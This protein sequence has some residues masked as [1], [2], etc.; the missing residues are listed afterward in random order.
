MFTIINDKN[1]STISTDVLFN[2]Y[3]S[4][5]AVQ[6]GVGDYYQA[7]DDDRENIKNGTITPGMSKKAVLMAYGYPPTH[8]TPLLTSDIWY[9]WY[10]RPSKVIVYFKDD[11]VF[12][13][14]RIDPKLFP[15]F[16]KSIVESEGGTK[17]R[18]KTKE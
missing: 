6:V 4:I 10:S 18:N 16:T 12:Q 14:E 3:F 15:I 8:K 5:E 17:S 1:T 9:Y 13:I 11:N 2:R 7:T